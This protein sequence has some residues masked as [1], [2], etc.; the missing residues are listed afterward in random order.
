MG[1]VTSQLRDLFSDVVHGRN[2]KYRYWN[3]AV[4]PEKT[5]ENR[6]GEKG[7]VLTR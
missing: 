1:P 5:A 6:A 4:Y 3:H 2:P 7:Q